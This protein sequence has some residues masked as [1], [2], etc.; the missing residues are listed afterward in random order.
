LV[1]KLL[2]HLLQPFVRVG[3]LGPAPRLLP[4][5]LVSDLRSVVACDLMHDEGM[6]SRAQRLEQGQLEEV[7]VSSEGR[8]DFEARG[9]FGGG[10]GEAGKT[11]GSGGGGGR[12]ANERVGSEGDGAT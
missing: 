12:Q 9:K 10:E 3:S 6:K 8:Y 11:I 1:D 2:L 5:V 7:W 4:L